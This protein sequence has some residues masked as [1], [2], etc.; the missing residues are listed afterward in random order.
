MRAGV[1]RAGGLRHARRVPRRWGSERAL[2][3]GAPLLIS[4]VVLLLVAV[5]AASGESA[6][7]VGQGWV[8]GI[9]Q[10]QGSVP[11][12]TTPSRP[13]SDLETPVA[14]RAAAA[15]MLAVIV[16]T[17]LALAL[18]GLAF[19]LYGLRMR[20]W[21]R[22]PHS[23]SPYQG[24]TDGTRLEVDLMRRAAGAL[25][26]LREWEGGP[27]G[28]A[29]VLAWLALEE[30]AAECGTT[31]HPHQTATEFT[32]AVLA[33]LDVDTD[34]LD[35]LRRLYQRARFSG[36]V[37]TEADV[38]TATRALERVVAGLHPHAVE[39]EAAR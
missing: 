20:R 17:M 22:R 21:R 14:V 28:D 1:H 9:G 16:L 23:T 32:T 6:V 11:P 33:G 25:R 24:V 34:A 39:E 31:R 37:V 18:V 38:D 29:V 5:L 2:P 4:V 15:L 13:E 36:N 26:R 3:P 19:M 10:Q 30:A 7:E 8:P 27:P 35:Q 12:T